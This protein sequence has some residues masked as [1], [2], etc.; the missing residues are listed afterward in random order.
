MQRALTET[1]IEGVKTSI[2]YHL[3]LLTDPYVRRG[4]TTIDFV[5]NHLEMWAATQSGSTDG[6]VA[7][8]S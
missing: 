4:E 7:R 8:V 1:R 6:Y 5:G 2:P 3:S